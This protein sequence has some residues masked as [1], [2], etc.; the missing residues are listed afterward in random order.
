MKVYL[1][2]CYII[3]KQ[4]DKISGKQTYHRPFTL[5]HPPV[6]W[7]QSRSRSGWWTMR[8]NV[9]SNEIISPLRQRG[10]AEELHRGNPQKLNNWVKLGFL[11]SPKRLPL[12]TSARKSWLP[13]QPQSLS[14][15]ALPAKKGAFPTA[16]PYIKYITAVIALRLSRSQRRTRGPPERRSSPPGPG[17]G[18]GKRGEM[19]AFFD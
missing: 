13:I 9:R 14:L 6:H 8:R 11:H 12:R 1:C 16:S 5:S 19:A 4:Y 7:D 17:G 3:M 18:A 10:L 15:G 2:L